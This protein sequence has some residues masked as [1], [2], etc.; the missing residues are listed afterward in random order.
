MDEK[1]PSQPDESSE[2]KESEYYPDGWEK[3]QEQEDIQTEEEWEEFI[4]RQY[5]RKNK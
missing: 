1:E 5:H 2:D 4:K 3:E